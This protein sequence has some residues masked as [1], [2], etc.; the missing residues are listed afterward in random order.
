MGGDRIEESG[1]SAEHDV[2]IS[3]GY[4]AG[5]DITIIQQRR[6]AVEVCRT[7]PRDVARFTGRIREIARIEQLISAE[8]L[9][10][11]VVI[12]DGPG[13][14]KSAFAVH[15]A[16]RL[17]DRYPDAQLHLRL[18]GDDLPEVEPGDALGRLLWALGVDAEALPVHLEDR[19]ALYRSLLDGRRA[20]VVLDNAMSEE[21]VE[22]LLL[23]GPGCAV[24]ITSR[25]ALSDL[26]GIRI[27]DLGRLSDDEAYALLSALIGT[28]RA[29]AEPEA[30]AEI[31]R[32]C[33]AL[34]LALRVAG[35]L[36][37]TPARR[38]ASVTAFAELL[39]DENT[40]LSVLR[41][42]HRE[43]RASFEL[44]YQALSPPAKSLLRRIGLLNVPD[45]GEGLQRAL[46]GGDAG[47]A[48]DELLDAYLLEPA[49]EAGERVQFHDLARLFARDCA[50]RE[51]AADQR[52]ATLDRAYAWCLDQAADRRHDMTA[53]ETERPLF[54]A[55][56]RQA[57]HDGRH[58]VAWRLASRLTALFEAHNHWAE[59]VEIDELALRSAT[60]LGD[61]R[62]IGT[63]LCDLAHAYRLTRRTH[64]SADAGR[65]ALAAFRGCGD[66]AGQ[67][68][69]LVQLGIVHRE[70]HRYADAAR[71]LGEG[72]EIL[73]D[74]GD[75]A[76]EGRLLKDLGHVLLWQ[77]NP[78]DAEPVLADA[79]TLLAES[80]DRTNEGWAYANLL[81]VRGYLWREAA[82]LE[83]Y[84]KAKSIFGE[85]RNR[86]GMA[87]A[88]NHVGVV[89]RQAG[90]LQQASECHE[91]ALG[92]FRDLDDKYGIGWALGYLGIT[93]GETAPIQE[94]R[95]VFEQIGESNGH[96]WTLTWLARSTG[97]PAL[98]QEALADFERVSNPQG[99][100]TALSV[101]GDLLRD[102]GDLAGAA[103]AYEEA[104]GPLRQAH[105]RHRE[106]LTLRGLAIADPDLAGEHRAR[107]RA[108][109]R[110]IGVEE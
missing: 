102:A 56:I 85:Q 57:A 79:V 1:A 8:P 25:Y 51:D 95:E 80:G 38:R 65:R 82:A 78:G 63:M 62:A 89:H 69:T 55:V 31:A 74:L 35:S 110:S 81:S 19:A 107:A 17:A 24:L 37:S 3:G 87:W 49:G 77:R 16:H 91:R 105:D 98:I 10:P 44:S 48:R 41:T 46:A 94:A 32:L 59:W 109:M 76:E 75:R 64:E 4:A 23:S 33:G 36:L 14:G 58:D 29:Q 71:Y 92:V 54:V 52:A 2:N 104:L 96:G 45:L 28:D 5:R 11:I 66:R 7:L 73:Q 43:V 83:A 106:A 61:Q 12:S 9:P 47:R 22:P 13:R 40:R 6:Q 18:G 101:R 99:I 88:D 103:T 100:G 70:L 68:A 30:V 53:L 21:Q 97:E 27:M 39:R 60:E 15:V 42:R 90:R 108:I 84:E 34:P 67:A 20:M 72:R 93:R 50:L 26:E 86:Q